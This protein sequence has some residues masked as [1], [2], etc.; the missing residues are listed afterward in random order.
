M[1]TTLPS[2]CGNSPRTTIVGDFVSRWAAGDTAGVSSW[3]SDDATWTFVGSGEHTGPD[4]AAQA[5]PA[6]PP[7]TLEVLSIVT[8]GRL[9]SCD[10]RLETDG[11]RVNFSHVFRFTGATKTA[12][13]AHVRTYLIEGA[14][15]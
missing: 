4:V 8:H 10:G 7:Q 6:V 14:D 5:I 15:R 13:I 12:K 9:A 1:E 11:K 2:D 3:L